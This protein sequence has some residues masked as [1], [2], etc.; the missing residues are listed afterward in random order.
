MHSIAQ[1]TASAN[2]ANTK[3]RNHQMIGRP[4]IQWR[5]QGGGGQPPPLWTKSRQP[6]VHEWSMRL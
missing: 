6:K 5:T 1:K 4:V 2:A 3:V